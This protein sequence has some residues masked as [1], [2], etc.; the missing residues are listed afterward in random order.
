VVGRST[1]EE[2][3]RVH[4]TKTLNK[5]V[6]PLLGYDI[7]DQPPIC[8]TAYALTG[9]TEMNFERKMRASM[10]LDMSTGLLQDMAYTAQRRLPAAS[11]RHSLINIV[12]T[13]VLSAVN[14]IVPMACSERLK[15]TLSKRPF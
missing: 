8:L 4:Q 11:L 12:F 9:V 15:K 13:R 3:E 10:R 2:K 6:L 1:H 14:L 7:G 5:A